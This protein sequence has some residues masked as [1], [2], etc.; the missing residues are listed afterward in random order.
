MTKEQVL[1]EIRR[2]AKERGGRVA[3][4][5]FLEAT[6]IPE[7]QILGRYWAT[8]N[9]ALAEAGLP[10]ARFLR[11]RF[12]DDS[13]IEPLAKL[14]ERLKKW[15]TENEMRLERHRDGCFRA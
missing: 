13:V 3:L 1:S 7:K 12:E 2:A 5:A 9:E 15:P 11:P 8:W 6:G 14:V 10:T 4:R